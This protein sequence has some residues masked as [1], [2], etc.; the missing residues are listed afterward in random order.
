MGKS[1]RGRKNP[2]PPPQKRSSGISLQAVIALVM[3][4]VLLGFLVNSFREDG[5]PS[6]P[7]ATSRKQAQGPF[8]LEG[9]LAEHWKAATARWCPRMAALQWGDAG[10]QG[11]L[12]VELTSIQCIARMC[13]QPEKLEG[14]DPAARGQMK[15]MCGQVELMFEGQMATLTKHYGRLCPELIQT[16][17]GRPWSPNNHLGLYGDVRQCME[18]HCEEVDG[19]TG[20]EAR[21]ELAA[22]LAEVFGDA[23][24]AAR[25]RERARLAK[26]RENQ[27]W[28][29]LSEE[30]K[31][32]EREDAGMKVI[33]RRLLALCRQGNQRYC[34]SLAKYCE[35]EGHPPDV[36]PA[37]GTSDAGR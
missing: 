6:R 18:R 34:A 19:G 5:Q 8:Q 4:G 7:A 32:E 35:I 29:P 25:L 3:G 10:Q 11:V 36:C 31:K 14:V 12:T 9:E 1:R 21:C 15:R 27:L 13:E 28:G 26:A 37:P 30:E 33:A 22:D 16:W 20:S 24:A 17:S 23:Q 2:T